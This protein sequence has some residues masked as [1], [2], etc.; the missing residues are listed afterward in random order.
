MTGFA[1]AMTVAV[2]GGAAL[3]HLWR[4]IEDQPDGGPDTHNVLRQFVARLKALTRCLDLRPSHRTFLANA[5]SS[6][7]AIT[8]MQSRRRTRQT[9]KAN[10]PLTVPITPP[11]KASDG[12]SSATLDLTL[13]LLVRALD[14]VVQGAC[15][16]K[17]NLTLSRKGKE[18]EMN[19]VAE[20][21]KKRTKKL[22]MTTRVDA[23]V[24]WAASARFDVLTWSS[25]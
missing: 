9:Y 7:V 21:Q 14:T 11:R 6:L 10:I 18:R 4:W 1:F 16:Q 8:L 25:T 5:L 17:A 20:T 19:V 2:G 24:F 15:L 22:L 3:D 12:R 13:L 23:F